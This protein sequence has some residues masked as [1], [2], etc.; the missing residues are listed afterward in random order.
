MGGAHR[1]DA[2]TLYMKMHDDE[3]GIDIDD[4]LRG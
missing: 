3:V 2:L 1:L 4:A